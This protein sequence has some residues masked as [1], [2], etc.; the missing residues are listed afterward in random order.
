MARASRPDASEIYRCVE[1]FAIYR[2]GVPVVY[3]NGAEV[4]GSDPILRTHRLHFEPAVER[5]LRRSGVE[6][7]TAA[8]GEFRDVS[9]PVES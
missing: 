4:M 2:D 6:Q 9:H 1:A 8:P 3:G 7:A 5:V